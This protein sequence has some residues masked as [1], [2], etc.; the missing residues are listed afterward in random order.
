MNQ[1]KAATVASAL[2]AANYNVTTFQDSTG[3]WHVTA[4]STTGATVDPSVVATFATN[5]TVTA[6]VG[7]ADFV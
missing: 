5:Q 3:A 6:K 7:T 1:A 4:A 2:I